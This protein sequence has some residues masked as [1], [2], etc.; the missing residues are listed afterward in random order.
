M[1]RSMVRLKSSPIVIPD[2]PQGPQ[3]RAKPGGIVL[4]QMCR[5]TI[6][7]M[8]F[9]TERAWHLGSWDRM[10]IPRPFARVGVA[11]GEPLRVARELTPE[12]LEAEQQRLAATLDGLQ[13]R[14][15]SA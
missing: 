15:K 2:G 9:H 7:P 5:T 13:D 14:A 10:I 8:G 12:G 6:V 3:Y 4:A 1:Y 11:V